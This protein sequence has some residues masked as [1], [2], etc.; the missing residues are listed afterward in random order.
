M[1]I[2]ILHN[3]VTMTIKDKEET[4]CSD[5]LGKEQNITKTNYYTFYGFEPGRFI[6]SVSGEGYIFYL[7]EC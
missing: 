5:E 2:A 6:M 7:P 4:N 3:T 1:E